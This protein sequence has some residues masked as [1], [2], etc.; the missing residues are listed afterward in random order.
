MVWQGCSGIWRSYLAIVI[1]LDMIK[2]RR[3]NNF[4]IGKT[5][6]VDTTFHF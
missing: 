4:T 2:Y 1:T 3:P 6:P 5:L